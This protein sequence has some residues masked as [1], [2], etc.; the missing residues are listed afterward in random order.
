[1]MIE[2]V[3]ASEV[4]ILERLNPYSNGMMIEPTSVTSLTETQF[5]LNPYSNGMM[6]EPADGANIDVKIDVLILILME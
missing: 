5:C 6:I 3:S 4:S 1:M 2:Q